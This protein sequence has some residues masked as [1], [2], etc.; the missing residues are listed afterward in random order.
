[1]RVIAGKARHLILVTPSGMNTRPTQDRIKETLFNILQPLLPGCVFVD[2]FAGSGQMGIEA[3]SRGAAVAYFID[4][5]AES[6]KCITENLTK[7]KLAS[8]GKL[9]KGDFIG[10]LS[11]VREKSADI[12][13]AD[14]PYE[15]GLYAPL[16]SALAGMS[17]VNEETMI[18]LET[19]SGQELSFAEYEGSPFVITRVKEY[20]TNQHVFLKRR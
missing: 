7:T 9:I 11:S 14:P 2:V 12:I 3:L 6:C 18:I 10:A 8:D 4:S 16:L 17:Y 15:A 19:K 5:G 13:F 1:M 20:K